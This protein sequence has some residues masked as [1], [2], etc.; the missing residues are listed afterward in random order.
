MGLTAVVAGVDRIGAIEFRSVRIVDT[1]ETNASQMEAEIAVPD[2]SWW[3]RSGNEIVVSTSSDSERHFAGS[4]IKVK[5]RATSRTG[6]R[7]SVLCQDY[8][9]LFDRR[10]V[11]TNYGAQAASDIVANIVSTYTTGFSTGGIQVGPGVAAQRFDY[12]APSAA[13]RDIAGQIHWRFYIDYA[14]VPQFFTAI[15]M[16]AP[17][18][19]INF[20]TSTGYSGLELEEDAAQVRNRIILQGYKTKSS[21]DFSRA[22]LGDS[23]TRFFFL[24]QEPASVSSSEI[25]VTVDGN[26]VDTLTDFV[27]SEPGSTVG[28][29]SQCFVC[30][31]NMGIRF[32]TGVTAPTSTVSVAFKFMKDGGLQYDDGAAQSE[33]AARSSGDGVHMANVNDPNLTNF[34]ANDDLAQA[35]GAAITAR[36]GFPHLAGKFDTFS[37]GWAPGQ[38]FT[39]VSAHRM[40]GFSKTFYTTQVEKSLVSHPSGG[41]PVW[42]YQVRI[43]DSPLP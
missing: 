23:T 18:T 4:I 7:Y 24:G 21:I 12:V 40:G 34:A 27:D 43:Q 36:Y 9:W 17:T 29:S 5:E 41:S 37:Q 13:I 30:F 26:P 33:M 1:I 25:S 8:T 19:G 32:S 38:Y 31:S 39:G 15:S 16:I 2:H 14:K 20:D 10:M 42:K 35:R 22:F 28:T 3:P 11:T 6:L